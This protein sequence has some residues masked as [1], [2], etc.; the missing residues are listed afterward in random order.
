[1][2]LHY[3]MI[4]DSL[5]IILLAATI[6]YAA[7]LNKR[8]SRLRD[9]R[10]ELEKAARSFAEAAGRADAGIRGLKQTADNVGGT[11]QKEI[12]RAAGLRDELT[13]LVEAGEALAM[14]LEGAAR[15]AGKTSRG[16]AA[17]R[18]EPTLRPVPEGAAVRASDT[19]RA[20]DRELLKAIEN[21][22]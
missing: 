3:P 7:I 14:R 13:F 20:P 9:N 16:T 1:M 2:T 10:A 8:L 17:G 11:L 21:M 18:V 22:R 15:G 4:L 12:G 5:I 19:G 6:V